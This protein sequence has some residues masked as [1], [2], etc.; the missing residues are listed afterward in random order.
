MPPKNCLTSL[1]RALARSP[2][3]Y[4]LPARTF[5]SSASQRKEASAGR[6]KQ[7]QTT[8]PPATSL[9]G[10]DAVDK[11]SKHLRADPMTGEALGLQDIDVRC[12][13]YFASLE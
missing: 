4:R 13:D 3:A 10:K 8:L 2:S 7:A 1:P 5:S 9:T 11:A 6:Q 12:F